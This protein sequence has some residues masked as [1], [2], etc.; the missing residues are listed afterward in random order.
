M[1][2]LMNRTKGRVRA[3]FIIRFHLCVMF[4][5]DTEGWGVRQDVDVR[6]ILTGEFGPDMSNGTAFLCVGRYGRADFVR[7]LFKDEGGVRC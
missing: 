5:E 4:N 6:A 3:V 7:F 2:S 1:G